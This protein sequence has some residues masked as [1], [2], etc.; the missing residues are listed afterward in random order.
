[1]CIRDSGKT[2]QHKFS[3]N[4]K[5][6]PKIESSNI[7]MYYPIAVSYT[8]LDVY[9]R[10]VFSEAFGFDKDKRARIMVFHLKEEKLYE[11]GL[12]D[13]IMET[14]DRAKAK[15]TMEKLDVYKRQVCPC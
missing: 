9:K 8:H 6:N 1:M 11:G 12:F 5:N 2:S 15:E 13:Q 14:L 10:Q 4:L 7:F 3:I